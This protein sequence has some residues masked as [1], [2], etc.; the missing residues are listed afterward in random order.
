MRQCRAAG[1]YFASTNHRARSFWDHKPGTPRSVP[2][3]LALG[4]PPRAGRQASAGADTTHVINST[5]KQEMARGQPATAF[6]IA[7][8]ETLH[9]IMGGH[10]PGFDR[11]GLL[12]R[13]PFGNAKAPTIGKPVDLLQRLHRPRDLTGRRQGGLGRSMSLQNGFFTCPS[14]NKRLRG[15]GGGLRLAA[16]TALASWARQR[17]D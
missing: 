15:E 11:E 2:R 10:P 16:V 13:H 12:R 1:S 8:L 3:W 14:P 5:T 7:A 9:L 17:R 4:T 6:V